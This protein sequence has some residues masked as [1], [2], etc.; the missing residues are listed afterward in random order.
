[1]FTNKSDTMSPLGNA[2]F[3]YSNFTQDAVAAIY[4]H[5]YSP[6]YKTIGSLFVGAIFSIG[7]LGNLMVVLVVWRSK[8]MH[9]PTNCY[10]VSLAVADILLLISAPLPTLIEFFI[11]VDQWIFGVVGCSMM[12]FF[13]FLGVN[14]SS[15]SITAFTVER[16]IAI[17]HPIRSQTICTVSRAMKIILGLWTFGI[18]YCVPWLA[19]TTT[20]TRVFSDGTTIECCDFKLKRSYY[21]TYFLTDLVL[22]YVIPLL[23]TSILYG[24]VARILYAS[25]ALR[26]VGGADRYNDAQEHNGATRVM[27]VRKSKRN[28]SRVQAS[29]I[30]G[31]IFNTTEIVLQKY[32]SCVMVQFVSLLD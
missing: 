30:I 26:G 24:L 9:T 17:C 22:F 27:R 12:V 29:R 16:Y 5:Y 1:M 13:Q 23:V 21:L 28:S 6:L 32:Q 11:V 3:N 10:L 7:F 8:A 4:P 19:L 31:H 20:R 18:L 2:L 25:R 14:V 15:L